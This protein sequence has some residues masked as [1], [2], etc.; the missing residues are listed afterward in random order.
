MVFKYDEENQCFSMELNN[1]RFSCETLDAHFDFTANRLAKEYESKLPLIAEYIVTNDKFLETY[2]EIS[3]KKLLQMFQE[4]TIPWIFLKDGNSGTIAYCDS[5]YVI[6]LSFTG[7][8]E[9]FSNLSI[10]S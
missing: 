5:N 8:F 1:I 4:M 9:K 10:D 6:E 3:R 2:G 7:D